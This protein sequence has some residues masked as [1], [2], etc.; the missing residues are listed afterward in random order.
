MKH[1]MTFWLRDGRS[2]EVEVQEDWKVTAPKV[3]G[4]PGF[5]I[6]YAGTRRLPWINASELVAIT[7]DK[8]TELAD[9]PAA[10]GV[11]EAAMG[12]VDDQD[13]GGMSDP[14]YVYTSSGT[15]AHIADVH[16][17][18]ATLCDR[19]IAANAGSS[20]RVC[21]R[22]ADRYQARLIYA[23]RANAAGM[24]PGVADRVQP[25]LR[26]YEAVVPAK[27]D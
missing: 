5:A 7:V 15:R 11:R 6:T 17:P 4:G 9:L 22:C 1:L 2:I 23:D 10:R 14:A 26:I 13:V 21:S 16:N 12:K 27:A 24:K 3:A 8:R 25:Q 18:G 20:K 19:R